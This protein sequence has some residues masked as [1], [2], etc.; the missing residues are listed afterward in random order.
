MS[1]QTQPPAGYEPVRTGLGFSDQLQPYYRR[2]DG[3]A[4]SFGL[5]VG[6]QHLNLMGICH[7]GALMTLADISAAT[8]VNAVLGAGRPLPTINLSFDFQSPGRRGHWLHTRADTVQVKRRFGFCSGLILDDEKVI[9]R[10]SGI[11]YIPEQP[12][13]DPSVE[14]PDISGLVGGGS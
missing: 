13:G 12:F 9:L 6:E 14:M 3:D 4:I 2:R 7:G 1:E 8:S 10:Y 11:F 5:F